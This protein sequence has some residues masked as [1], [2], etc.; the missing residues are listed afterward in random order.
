MQFRLSLA[1]LW[2]FTS[3][4]A[5]GTASAQNPFAGTWKL[6]QE[7]SRMTGDII[8]F[9]PAADDSMELTRDGVTYS[10]RADG[11][12]Y[13]VPSG[14]AAIWRQTG[15]DSWTTEHRKLDNKLL[16]IDHWQLSSD[17][18]SLTVTTSGAKANEDL[19]TNTAVYARTEG[20]SGLLGSWKSTSV[21][22]NSPSKLVIQEQ[23]LDRLVF[24][25]A[26]QKTRCE[27]TMD[28]KE[29]AVDGPDIPAGLRLSLTRTGPYSLQLVEK[30]NGTTTDSSLYTLA[31]DDPQV[32][33]QV[34]GAP[35]NA[36]ATLVWEKQPEPKPELKTTPAAD[37]KT[38]TLSVPVHP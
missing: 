36:P 6:N 38:A 29:T 17:G 14:D 1:A 25:V 19:Y 18:K 7:K 28:G 10:F 15:P 37:K 30:L 4:C 3:I 35:G 12:T 26:A 2:L 5:A 33:T 27:L 8:R 23:G 22:L 24:V 11:N 32:M 31:A 21:T 34:G 16:N 9:G 20:T 13:A